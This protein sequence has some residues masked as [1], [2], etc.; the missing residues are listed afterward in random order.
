MRV[1]NPKTGKVGV[2]C[3][4]C[5]FADSRG[6]NISDSMDILCNEW[7]ATHDCA[8]PTADTY[9]EACELAEK[10]VQP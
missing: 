8:C 6:R 3:T 4:H 9:A 2:I 5:P 10:G 1:D 7:G